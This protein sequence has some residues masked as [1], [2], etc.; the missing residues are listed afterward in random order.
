[1]TTGVS[2]LC[3]I[4]LGGIVWCVVSVVTVLAWAWWWPRHGWHDR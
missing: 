2:W 4:A 3:A 1:M